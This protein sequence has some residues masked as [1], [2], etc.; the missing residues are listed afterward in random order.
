MR[1][2]NTRAP[3]RMRSGQDAC[4]GPGSGHK[5]AGRRGWGPPTSYAN[6]S[7]S[8][9]RLDQRPLPAPHRALRRASLTHPGCSPKPSRGQEGRAGGEA[10]ILGLQLM[11]LSH[12]QPGLNRCG[13][14]AR[15]NASRED[16]SITGSAT[17]D[18]PQK[19]T[20][21]PGGGSLF[22]LH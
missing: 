6:S 16:L 11:A 5:A 19:H 1:D 14:H 2:S 15:D 12:L 18:A 22:C 3:A 21:E 13:G 10:V 17:L 9:M 8:G 4:R 20:G 7:C